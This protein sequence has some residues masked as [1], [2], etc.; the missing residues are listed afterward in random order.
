MVVGFL[1]SLVP[2]TPGNIGASFL[3]PVYEDLH[4]L[5]TE[6]APNTKQAFF[7]LWT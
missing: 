2:A 6:V 5:L 7:V 3:R 4:N 1:Q